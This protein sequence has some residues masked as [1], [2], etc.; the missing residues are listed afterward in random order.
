LIS[1]KARRGVAASHAMMDQL[2]RRGPS[3]RA[4][5]AMACAMLLLSGL[6]A[7]PVGVAAAAPAAHAMMT[8]GGDCGMPAGKADHSHKATG[9]CASAHGC[10]VLAAVEA[11]TGLTIRPA[12][13]AVLLSARRLGAFERVPPLPPPILRPAPF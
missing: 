7:G 8:P 6:L 1:V 5:L 9:A 10:L 13:D 12:A 4:I 3:L 2:V 11:P